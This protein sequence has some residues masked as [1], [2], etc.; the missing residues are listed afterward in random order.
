MVERLLVTTKEVWSPI[1]SSKAAALL[2]SLRKAAVTAD[3]VA[4]SQQ[5]GCM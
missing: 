2:L 3:F 4:V 5:S 1:T